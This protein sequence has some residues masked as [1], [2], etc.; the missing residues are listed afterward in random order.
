MLTSLF[1]RDFAVVRQLELSL[2]S[3]LT[4]FTGE[5]GAGKSI[6][7]DALA[8]ALGE[9]ADTDVIRPGCEQAEIV[10]G[11]HLQQRQDA[12]HW[13]SAHDLFED[14][15][16]ILRRVLH[17]ERASRGFINGR[18][19]P[20]QMLR[21]LGER[22]V[23]IHGQHEHQSLLRRDAQ[24]QILDDAAGHG[25][26]VEAL[27]ATYGELRALDERTESMRARG[28]DRDARLDLLR[29]QVQELDALALA[30]GELDQLEQEHERLAHSSELVEGVQTLCTAL[31]DADEGTLA[32]GLGH[33]VVRLQALGV[34]DPALGEVSD[35]LAQAAVQVEEASSALRRYLDRLDLDPQRLEWV[36]QRLGT[37][38]DLARKHRVRPAELPEVGERLRSELSELEELDE[39]L[40]L[41]DQERQGLLGRYAEQA[42]AVTAGRRKA[43]QRLNKRVTAQMHELG[44]QGGRFE[45]SLEPLPPAT[46]TAYGL[47]RVDFL[48]TANPGQP[49][50]P[51]TKVASGGELSRISLALQVEIASLGRVPTLIF[52]EVDVGIGGGVAEIVG[53]KLRT[54]GGARQVLCIT[55]LA[56]VAAQGSHQWR[57]VKQAEPEVEVSIEPLAEQSRVQEIARMIGGVT[58]TD[59][60]LAHARE[61]L[62]RAAAG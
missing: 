41:L 50:R 58:I 20:M 2:E 37:V 15:E 55:H 16:C 35:M 44:M 29:Y 22:L 4:V 9:R 51:L 59:Q 54:L 34:I 61:M 62:D 18:P 46:P 13:L 60:T 42:S 57:V 39:R 36:D 6:M 45:A 47:D 26:S 11:F 5:T 53:Q 43:A 31:Y 10:A 7:V 33:A 30:D 25:E 56:Q 32:E 21:E 17:R 52:D 49:P 1:I 24:R 8:L 48:V 12:A 27:A 19:V 14:G 40:S 38:H 28:H 3:G 23:D